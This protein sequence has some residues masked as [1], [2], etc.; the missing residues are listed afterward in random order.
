[1]KIRKFKFI[2]LT[3]ASMLPSL[4][5]MAQD[6][7]AAGGND[8]YFYER[9]G[10]Y[11]LVGFASAVMI[12]A[13]IILYRLLAIMIKVQQIKIYQ[14][15]G[16]EEYLKDVQEPK[17]WWT[18]VMERWEDAVPIEKEG[19]IL[20]DHNYDG[21]RELDNNLPPW[22]VAMFYITIFFAA[23][24][25]TYYHFTDMGA[26]SREEYATEM[27]IAKE[28]V[29]LYRSKQAD[30]VTEENVVALTEPSA[31]EGGKTTF[32]TLCATCHGQNGE[33]G[34]GPNMTDDYFLH[35]CGIKD[36]FKTIKYGVP[37]KGMIS[38]QDQLRPSE[39]QAVAS[40][41]MTLRGNTVENPKEP[42]GEECK[43]PT[44]NEEAPAEEV[45]TTEGGEL[46]MIN[47]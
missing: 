9:F 25:L 15:Q 42:Q 23:G 5:L 37:E 24:Y 16:L 31:L 33:G 10:S 7:A 18:R 19:D 39:M 28:Q 3:L 40:Y 29:A 41:I 38:W 21:I 4:G 27:E 43:P 45:E 1:M 34:V 20:M 36:V 14:E 2:Y 11:I 8:P 44:A 32:M 47:Q 30:Q 13:V 35:G 26:G 46:G 17:S 12:T 22:W 6:A